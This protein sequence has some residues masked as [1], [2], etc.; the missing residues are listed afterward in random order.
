MATDA[1]QIQM[2]TP[3]DPDWAAFQAWKAEQAKANEPARP[4]EFYTHLADGRVVTL[5]EDELRETGSHY[6]DVEI[7]GRYQVGA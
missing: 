7:I 2:N 4:A 3:A 1:P 5:T 6:E